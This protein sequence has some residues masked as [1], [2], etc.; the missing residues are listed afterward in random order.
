MKRLAE[1]RRNLVVTHDFRN[2]NTTREA[3]YNNIQLSEDL[4]TI[5]AIPLTSSA[6]NKTPTEL[7]NEIQRLHASEKTAEHV[8]TKLVDYFYNRAD[9]GLNKWQVQQVVRHFMGQRTHV[10]QDDVSTIADL[11]R[12]KEKGLPGAN[13]A[14]S[15][16][17]TKVASRSQAL[18]AKP[19][20]IG[21]DNRQ[22][23]IEANNRSISQENIKML[24][25]MTPS[26][27][28]ANKSTIKVVSQSALKKPS[29]R[30]TAPQK[31]NMDTN[32]P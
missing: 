14:V 21:P 1:Q 2:H 31:R 11:I 13:G 3:I 30:L 22:K 27:A 17:T 4:A 25:Q 7:V 29:M 12:V 18:R 19:I 16:P 10:S 6:K 8:Q 26:T 24:T 32:S 20:T 28:A 15:M 23:S 9:T 5:K